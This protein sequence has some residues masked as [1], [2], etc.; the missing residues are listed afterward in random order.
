MNNEVSYYSV[1]TV[2]TSIMLTHY[3]YQMYKQ[4]YNHRF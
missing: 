3:G 4:G 2:S 1:V